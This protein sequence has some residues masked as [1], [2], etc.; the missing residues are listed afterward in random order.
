MGTR[1]FER[2]LR[3]IRQQVASLTAALAERS[4][5][6]EGI[7]GEHLDR[8]AAA[9]LA[10]RPDEPRTAVRDVLGELG[11]AHEVD[12]VEYWLFDESRSSVRKH[13]D[14]CAEGVL[15]APDM[16]TTL[17]A[18]W[19]MERA[20]A[21]DVV[22]INSPTEVAA[23]LPDRALFDDYAVGASVLIP[24]H[25]EERS[26]GILVF[27]SV[28]P[29]EW[30]DATV[31]QMSA[32]A[33]LLGSTWARLDAEEEARRSEQRFRA[34]VETQSDFIVRWTP[35]GVRTFVNQAYCDYFGITES[36][37]LGTSFFPLISDED[38]ERVQARL[39]ALCP[40]TPVTSDVHRVTL[41]D[42]TKGWQHWT[43][44]AF[45]DE[46][47]QV[48]E[49]QSVGRDV[50][51]QEQTKRDLE[52]ELRRREDAERELAREL[53]HS[54]L[55]LELSGTLLGAREAEDDQAIVEAMGRLAERFGFERASLWFHEGEGDLLRARHAWLPAGDEMVLR[56][57]QRSDLSWAGP[58]IER[59]ERVVARLETLPPDARAERFV[60]EATGS[61]IC[62]MIPF[63]GPDFVGV[64]FFLASALPPDWDERIFDEL[65][66]ATQLFVSA[67]LRAEA[68]RAQRG[69]LD[70]LRA[71]KERVESENVYLRE[72]VRDALGGEIV[73]RSAAI[74]ETFARIDRVAGTTTTVLIQGETGTGKEL[75]ARELHRRSG[76]RDAPL[77]TMNCAAVPANLVESEL[78]GH[79]RG[80]F[81]GADRRRVGRFALADGG[82]L[83]LDEIGELPLES[84]SKLLRALQ[85]GEIQPVGGSETVRVD[86]RVLASTNRDLEQEVARGA[87]RADL[88]YR[89]DVYPIV[90]P[91]LRDRA[92]D[93]PALVRHFIR[94]IAPRVGSD[95]ERVS[96]RTLR[97]LQAYRWPGNVRE[98]EN[99][100]ERALLGASGRVL[101]VDGPVE[102]HRGAAL[103][104]LAHLTLREAEARHVQRVL[105]SVGWKVEGADG[106]AE[107]LGVAPSTLR[108]RM[109]KLGIARPK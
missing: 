67:A 41:P 76:R 74:A 82:T 95:V 29:R 46:R 101:D 102:G 109:R 19:F 79:E 53:E 14:W 20:L 47:G 81:T 58:P 56:T 2:E 25:V 55:L 17:E 97:Q 23:D 28:E 89:L 85:E 54:R 59:G 61:T 43:D 94:K 45:F 27:V 78:F 40:D 106:A 15:P 87:F 36:D 42:G 70:E 80:A 63:P 92:E 18:G 11:A 99:F 103:D 66:F 90:V 32:I 5:R 3:D 8:I 104:D 10:L 77:V 12:R 83:L 108:S 51:G 88:F 33:R 35:G 21:R 16:F 93:I 100:V 31:R 9:L 71:L 98:L 96:K 107:R 44:H 39:D 52:R 50:T 64:A 86:V 1:D 62:V 13:V 69:A 65:E 37:A 68:Q 84:Q 75:V 49:V 30:S 48:R 38:R 91:P 26:V 34:V 72:E 6:P 105:E 24:I 73:G 22:V 7:S 4:S 60:L 57:V